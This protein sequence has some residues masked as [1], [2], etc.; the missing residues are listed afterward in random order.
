MLGAC[1]GL[2]TLDPTRV[3]SLGR[4]CYRVVTATAVASLPRDSRRGL[5]NE[6]LR[7]SAVWGSSSAKRQPPLAGAEAALA[8]GLAAAGLAAGLAV[9]AA[10]FAAV[11]A[12]VGFT[13]PVA[14][15]AGAAAGAAGANACD[16]GVVPPSTPSRPPVPRPPLTVCAL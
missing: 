12:A 3:H 6:K 2:A 5:H 13:E 15:A 16:A 10:G 1:R 9:V 8:G 7:R 14:A 4:A 11:V